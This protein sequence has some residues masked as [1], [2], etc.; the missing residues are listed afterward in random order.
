MTLGDYF[1]LQPVSDPTAFVVRCYLYRLPEI[2]RRLLCET[3]GSAFANAV[4]S[5]VAASM[6]R[7]ACPEKVR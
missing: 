2:Q 4:L 3:C 5:L 6:R 1:L 7:P